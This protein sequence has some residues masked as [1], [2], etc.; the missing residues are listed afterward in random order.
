VGAQGTLQA[1]REGRNRAAF[2]LALG[3]GLSA[4]IG[5]GALAGAIVLALV[6]RT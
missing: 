1:G 3:G 5:F 2:A 6:W 4:M